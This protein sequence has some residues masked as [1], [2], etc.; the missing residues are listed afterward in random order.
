[1]ML[2]L[3]WSGDRTRHKHGDRAFRSRSRRR[4][5][6]ARGLPIAVHLAPM[7][8]VAFLLLIFFLVTTTFERAEGLLASDLPD[9]GRPPAVAL[10]ISPIVMRLAQTG[11]GHD[12][13]LIKIDRFQNVPRTFGALADFLREV[14]SRPGFDEQ[15]PV[16]I[17]ADNQVRWDHVVNGWNAA[18]RAGYERIAFAEP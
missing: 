8:D 16:V 11:Q 6:R 7:I 2:A 18:L 14:Q 1:M 15:T 12:D 10:P 13:F 3:G 4:R 9:D 17:V 5:A